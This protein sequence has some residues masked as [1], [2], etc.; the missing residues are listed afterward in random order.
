MAVLEQCLQINS[1]KRATIE[2][3]LQSPFFDSIR[4]ELLESQINSKTRIEIKVDTLNFDP[5][6]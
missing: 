2:A 4:S 3:C 6:T 5:V 1:K